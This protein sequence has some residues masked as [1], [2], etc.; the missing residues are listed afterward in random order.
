MINKFFI[1]LLLS[2]TLYAQSAFDVLSKVQNKFQSINNFEASF[3]QTSIKSKGQAGIKLSGKFFYEKKNKFNVE[4]NY[5]N[6]ICDGITV[7]NYNKSSKRVVVSDLI[8]DPTSFS[9]E[10]FIFDYPP[11]CTMTLVNDENVKKVGA[12]L[13]LV[14]KNQKLKFKKA[15]ISVT[16]DG[17]VSKMEITDFSD[18]NYEFQFNEIKINQDLPDSKFTFSPPKG[19]Q[20]I[21]LR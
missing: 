14:P 21:D 4:L 6:I 7:W 19:I 20:I 13:E 15:K 3:S 11:Q 18:I 9:L 16:S 5:A 10:R 1:C 12:Q 8:N 17:M 2:S